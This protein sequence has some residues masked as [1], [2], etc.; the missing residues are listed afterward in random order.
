L[1]AVVAASAIGPIAGGNST[2]VTVTVTLFVAL[3]Y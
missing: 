2:G 3:P 1:F